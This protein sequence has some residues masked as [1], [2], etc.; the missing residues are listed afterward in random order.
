MGAE[1]AQPNS[2]GA[3]IAEPNSTPPREQA[4]PGSIPDK[5]PFLSIVDFLLLYSGPFDVSL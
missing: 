5:T 3:E 4:A 2:T 1:I